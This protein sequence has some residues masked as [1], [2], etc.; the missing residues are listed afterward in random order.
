MLRGADERERHRGDVVASGRRAGERTL[1]A[2]ARRVPDRDVRA[3]EDRDVAGRAG[4][5]GPRSAGDVPREGDVLRDGFGSLVEVEVAVRHQRS[6]AA[7]RETEGA[8]R[9]GEIDR[10]SVRR[11]LDRRPGL[12]RSLREVG[13]AGLGPVGDRERTE[14]GLGDEARPD[15]IEGD[16]G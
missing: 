15:G 11:Q 8:Q 10:G 3:G 12:S 6:E 4:G 1:D 13:G 7:I 14:G 5:R 16:R 9:L 2:V